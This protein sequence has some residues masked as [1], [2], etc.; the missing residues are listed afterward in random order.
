MI[1]TIVKVRDRAVY[2]LGRVLESYEDSYPLFHLMERPNVRSSN[3]QYQA[4]VY[5]EQV[6]QE[7]LALGME[8]C[9]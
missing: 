1:T 4:P 6:K 7:M 9:S 5:G 2:L 8:T 3:K